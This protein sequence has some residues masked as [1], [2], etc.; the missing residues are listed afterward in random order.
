MRNKVL[1]RISEKFLTD[2]FLY[3]LLGDLGVFQSR[4]AMKIDNYRC[5]NYGIMEQ[6]MLSFAAGISIANCYPI[7]YSITPFIIERCFEQLKLD[8]GY[9]KSKGL[10]IT[11]G[12]SF[13]YNKLGPSHYSPND[14][15]LITKT[16]CKNILLPWNE[17][18]AVQFIDKTIDEKLYTYLRISS[19]EID[20]SLKPK[21]LRFEN[22]IFQDEVFLG[23][24]PDSLL[25]AKSLNYN[26]DFSIS[27]IDEALIDNILNIISKGVNLNIIAGFNL[28]F[29]F[30]FLNKNERPNFSNL[31][32]STINL[33]YSMNTKFDTSETKITHLTSNIF[34]NKFILK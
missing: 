16:D 10:I 28:D 33:I 18:D 23:I 13:D 15:S 32:N 8:F 4:E 24:G 25:I 27:I 21:D 14:I 29:L 6:S 26:L 17:K 2:E 31:H 5:I 7:I 34:S 1:E 12:A 11:A 22:D 30:N 3:L 20:E 19:E 9:N